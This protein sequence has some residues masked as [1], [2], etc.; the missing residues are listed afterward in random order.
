VKNHPDGDHFSSA[1]RSVEAVRAQSR[2]PLVVTIDADGARWSHRQ[3]RWYR[4]S[5]N[6]RRGLTQ[7]GS[8]AMGYSLSG[9]I[10]EP[11]VAKLV[12]A[13]GVGPG[14]PAAGGRAR[15]LP[16]VGRSFPATL[17]AWP[18]TAT[19]PIRRAIHP[20]PPAI[21]TRQSGEA[22]LWQGTG[23][24]L[25]GN[26]ALAR[27]P[28]GTSSP[29]FTTHCAEIE[30]PRLRT[31]AHSVTVWLQFASMRPRVVDTGSDPRTPVLW[32]LE[33]LF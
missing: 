30:N 27:P 21:L 32:R 12:A 19:I 3:T 18:H 11:F 2:M 5:R 29:S 25:S 14:R 7:P 15:R 9:A 31:P 8:T 17:P 13:S 28:T 23:C 16:R 1:R 22:G 26:D 20:K 6:C 4:T 24:R 10:L 33:Q